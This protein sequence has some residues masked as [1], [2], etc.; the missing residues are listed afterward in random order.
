MFWRELI[1]LVAI[2][3]AVWALTIVPEALP[4]SLN[5][6]TLSAVAHANDIGNPRRRTDYAAKLQDVLSTSGRTHV[7]A[8]G[9]NKTVLR[10]IDPS[11]FRRQFTSLLR[12][13]WNDLHQQGFESV[14]LCPNPVQRC[15]EY[16]F[17]PGFEGP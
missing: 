17:T 7:S 3:A 15:A 13:Y 12:P 8:E 4:S 9:P 1:S 16:F 2:A 11:S 10:I 5:N 14:L 6:F